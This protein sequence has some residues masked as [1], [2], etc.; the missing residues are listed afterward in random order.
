[1]SGWIR[2]E[3]CVSLSTCR[4]PCILH[5]VCLLCLH[6]ETQ[7]DTTGEDL[8]WRALK[9]KRLTVLLY[10]SCSSYCLTGNSCCLRG[11]FTCRS[12]GGQKVVMRL[13]THKIKTV[14]LSDSDSS[15]RELLLLRLLHFLACLFL[16][17]GGTGDA[18][19][20]SRPRGGFDVAVVIRWN[21]YHLRAADY[22][23]SAASQRATTGL[24]LLSSTPSVCVCVCVWECVCVCVC[25]CGASPRADPSIWWPP[26]HLLLPDWLPA[27]LSSRRPLVAGCETCED[28]SWCDISFSTGRS[29]VTVRHRTGNQEVCLHSAFRHPSS[30]R[31]PAS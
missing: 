13:W 8:I 2:C 21:V 1:M 23:I 25:V 11:D 28:D 9:R 30:F 10:V 31:S 6:P 4:P 18:C 22:A 7:L 29:E 24:C 12:S 15:R 14:S 5:P 19:N 27:E 16:K 20:P 26:S 17:H 3:V